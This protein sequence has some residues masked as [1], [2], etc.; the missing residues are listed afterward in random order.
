[1]NGIDSLIRERIASVAAFEI[2]TDPAQ[3]RENV[4]RRQRR[5]RRRRRTA[6]LVGVLATAGLAVGVAGVLTE[7]ASE[8]DV[9][10]QA[11]QPTAGPGTSAPPASDVSAAWS[12]LPAG[13]LAPR[14]GYASVWTGRELLIW[15]GAS[16]EPS[17]ATYHSDGAAYDAASGQWR[18]LPEAPFSGRFGSVTVWTGTEMLV[19]GGED[20]SGGR[21]DAVAYTPGSDTWRVLPS[22]LPRGS[23]AIAAIWSDDHA[24]VAVTNGG[25]SGYDPTGIAYSQGVTD[26]V[27]LWPNTSN[28]TSLPA[29]PISVNR[30]ID[31]V[32][33]SAGELLV[34]GLVDELGNSLPDSAGVVVQRL[35]EGS[36]G[37]TLLPQVDLLPQA[38]AMADLDGTLIAVDYQLG[39][40]QSDD[41]GVGWTTLSR[42]PLDAMEC[43]PEVVPAD[44]SLF[45]WYCGQ[46]AILNPSKSWVPVT[47]PDLASTTLRGIDTTVSWSARDLLVWGRDVDTGETLML[48]FSPEAFV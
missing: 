31:F 5:M 4:A 36:G 6:V 35:D 25:D 18:S 34:G 11:T 32:E 45:V 8:D 1:M 17:G 42:I 30:Q 43:A 41:G 22:G 7:V 47:W 37:W 40:T 46:A 10:V 27:Q 13:P 16:T 48:A 44:G 33:S 20:D 29:P 38:V 24:V 23:R 21:L 19:I 15:G 14:T 28:W 12:R 9:A 2:V 39:T 26:V 3:V